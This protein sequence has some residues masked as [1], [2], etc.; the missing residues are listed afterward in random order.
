VIFLCEDERKTQKKTKTRCRT[1]YG[2]WVFLWRKRMSTYQSNKDI[3]NYNIIREI[4]D[5]V[6]RIKYGSINIKVHDAKVVQVEVTE[7]SRYDDWFVEKGSG[8]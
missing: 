2:E 5:S 8:I 7:K 1:I 3:A 6:K 4:L